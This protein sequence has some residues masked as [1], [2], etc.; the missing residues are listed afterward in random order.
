MS[1]ETVLV[2]GGG[3]NQLQLINEAKARGLRVVV[4]DM[5][6]NPPAKK[7][8][9][10]FFQIDTTNRTGTLEIAQL[11][12]AGA[13]ITDQSDVAVP[14]AA[15]VAECLGLPGIGFETSLKF[16][17]KHVMR[18][19]LQQ[20]DPD[21][22]PKSVFFDESSELLRFVEGSQ[23]SPTDFLIKPINS[24]G[25]KGVAR[26]KTRTDD[27]AV[28][29]AFREARGQGVLLEQFIAG[30]EFSVEAFVVD[31]EVMNLAVTRKFHFPQNDCIDFRNT[32][33]GDVSVTL[34]QRLYDAN[35]RV[36]SSLGLVTGSTHAEFKVD[37]G[38][39]YLMEIAARGGG[40]N[41]SGKII[42]YLTGFSPTA[43]LL[44]FALGQTPQVKATDYRKR[45]AL[46]RFFDFKPGTVSRV[47]NR[48][49]HH[50]GLLH[51]ELNLEP[52]NQVRSVL[53]SRDRVGYFIVADEERHKALE[54]EQLVLDSVSI[55][56]ST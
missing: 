50:S 32:Y 7:V 22:L 17:N 25:S 20:T 49:E 51:F 45:F 56:Y 39:I 53:S 19:A 37:G 6:L 12:N 13:V 16:T 48:V 10:E 9:D 52:G 41:I 42:P 31:G 40:G 2:I 30:D 29:T 28:L 26:L 5:F 55:E 35:S 15:Y 47:A 43:A 54:F 4:T 27:Q 44:D 21:L 23:M 8:A 14:T 36:I 34:Q 3:N 24:Q 46:L 33:L 18:T 11:T 38:D 1:N